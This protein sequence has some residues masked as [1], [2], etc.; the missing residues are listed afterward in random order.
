MSFRSA[1][2]LSHPRVR[3]HSEHPFIASVGVLP[4]SDDREIF[5]HISRA[6]A[7][8]PL[9]T[10][11]VGDDSTVF[12]IFGMRALA[13]AAHIDSILPQRTGR[14]GKTPVLGAG[15][16]PTPRRSLIAAGLACVLLGIAAPA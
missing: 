13:V 2:R 10:A 9:G 16:T 15:G 1:M 11:S 6:G 5:T 8:A 12:E 7:M 4:N 3:R 14:I